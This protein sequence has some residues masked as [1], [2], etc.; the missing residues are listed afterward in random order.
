MEAVFKVA[1]TTAQLM[2]LGLALYAF[3]FVPLGRKTCLE[4]ARAIWATPEAQQAKQEAGQATSRLLRELLEYR[5]GPLRGDPDV[6][7]FGATSA[8]P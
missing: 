8:A 1:K 7:N 4:H 5:S 3:A 2:I 6:P